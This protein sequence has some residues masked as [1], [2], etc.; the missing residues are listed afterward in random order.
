MTDRWHSAQVRN[1]MTYGK[2][3]TVQMMQHFV[4]IPFEY[5][6]RKVAKTGRGSH[7]DKTMREWYDGT[8]VRREPV[9]DYALADVHQ[10]MARYKDYIRIS[11][12]GDRERGCRPVIM[13]LVQHYQKTG[14]GLV[15]EVFKQAWAYYCSLPSASE[16]W[17]FFYEPPGKKTEKPRP[18]S[19]K[20]FLLGFFELRFAL[21][22]LLAP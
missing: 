1:V 2:T 17:D 9:P 7:H 3:V 6:V 4:D 21:S 10:T 22:R 12:L 16:T 5:E 18:V 15:A 11:V 19:E 14:Q 20:G 13:K 8:E